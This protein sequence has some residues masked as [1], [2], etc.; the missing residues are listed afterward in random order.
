MHFTEAV[1]YSDFSVVGEI[2]STCAASVGGATSV[3]TSGSGGS[4]SASH[5]PASSLVKNIPSIFEVLDEQEEKLPS[6]PRGSASATVLASTSSPASSSV[7][8]SSQAPTTAKPDKTST[9]SKSSTS[10]SSSAAAAGSVPAHAKPYAPITPSVSRTTSNPFVNRSSGRITAQPTVGPTSSS[11]ISVVD[12]CEA[13]KETNFKPPESNPIDYQALYLAEKAEKE[14]VTRDLLKREADASTLAFSLSEKEAELRITKQNIASSNSEQLAAAKAE[15]EKRSKDIE[16]LK[17]QLVFAQL[18]GLSSDAHPNASSTAVT[19]STRASASAHPSSS[20]TS[21]SRSRTAPHAPSSSSL[22]TTIHTSNS[23]PKTPASNSQAKKRNFSSISPLPS[24]ALIAQSGASP[25]KGFKTAEERASRFS[26]LRAEMPLIRSDFATSPLESA[27]RTYIGDIDLGEA[28]KTSSWVPG[29]QFHCADSVAVVSAALSSPMGPFVWIQSNQSIFSSFEDVRSSFARLQTEAANFLSRGASVSLKRLAALN[30]VSASIF[31]PS[32]NRSPNDTVTSSKETDEANEN[33]LELCLLQSASVFPMI[34]ETLQFAQNVSY[35]ISYLESARYSSV[36]STSMPSTTPALF[37]ATAPATRAAVKSSE[38]QGPTMELINYALQERTLFVQ[39]LKLLTEILNADPLC[40]C[41][42][43][44]PPASDCADIVAY[45]LKS[46]KKANTQ[47]VPHTLPEKLSRLLSRVIRSACDVNLFSTASNWMEMLIFAPKNT[48]EHSHLTSSSSLAETAMILGAHPSPAV[49]KRSIAGQTGDGAFSGSKEDVSGGTT[50]NAA[51]R[52]LA[53]MAQEILES[54]LLLAVSSLSEIHRMS[55]LS[56]SPTGPGKMR[57]NSTSSPQVELETLILLS[58]G[59]HPV[60]LPASPIET[61]NRSFLASCSTIESFMGSDGFL[62]ALTLQATKATNTENR[63]LLGGH[64]LRALNYVS[65]IEAIK[66]HLPSI[67]LQSK[68]F[69]VYGWSPMTTEDAAEV[70]FSNDLPKH[71]SSSDRDLASQ[72]M[73]SR[74][75]LV[76]SLLQLLDHRPLALAQALSTSPDLSSTSN[77]TNASSTAPQIE[78]GVRI[79]SALMFAIAQASNLLARVMA[80]DRSFSFRVPQTAP[81]ALGSSAFTSVDLPLASTILN[82][83]QESSELVERL[84]PIHPRHF[85]L[86]RSA[87]PDIWTAFRALSGVQT[88]ISH[89]EQ[90]YRPGTAIE[91]QDAHNLSGSP[92]LTPIALWVHQKLAPCTERVNS[93]LDTF[94][95]MQGHL[96]RATIALSIN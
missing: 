62:R 51:E 11:A 54:I 41:L 55:S 13:E 2:G 32:T 20:P 53:A 42:V 69:L 93:V 43:L 4:L 77:S 85:P 38:N 22:A 83:I 23:P 21:L 39:V 35:M 91:G 57:L 16:K 65:P 6:A 3:S 9:S 82:F 49:S 68:S 27:S 96:R 8:L 30:T 34:Y 37:A 36:G 58:H 33:L 46:L 24:S 89:M 56:T 12:L 28:P 88:I 1:N 59:C 25:T 87:E 60:L 18:E 79:I 40:R 19:A 63:V 45:H 15:L 47:S 48:Y 50:P 72:V 10:S 61:F 66:L 26:T 64:A 84:L 80:N 94:S 76:R 78:L 71:S 5:A 44:T 17:S 86:L 52:P 95:A 74:L 67:L 14:R 92:S 31:L 73:C 29:L 70:D 90:N 7:V 81:R 75:S